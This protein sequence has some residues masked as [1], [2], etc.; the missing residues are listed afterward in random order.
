MNKAFLTGR[1]S[2]DLELKKVKDY[3][4][5]EF[6]L[7]TNRPTTRDGKRETDFINCMVWGSQAENLVKYQRKGNLL[8]V[9]G[10]LR[11][12]KFEVEGN[13]RYKTYILVNNIE[14]LESKKDMSKEESTEFNKISSKTE[15]QTSFEYDD[16][17]LPWND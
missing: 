12:D 8:G 4:V 5:C 11:T 13:T 17:D 9:F 1:I 14:F 2:K 3:K 6:T 10:E 15:T 16:T 7:A